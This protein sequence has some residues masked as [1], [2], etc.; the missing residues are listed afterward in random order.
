[1]RQTFCKGSCYAELLSPNCFLGEKLRLLHRSLT[2]LRRLFF[3]R[4]LATAETL[5]RPASYSIG[6]P[7]RL[8]RE[9]PFDSTMEAA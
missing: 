3:L 4:I 9:V 8:A 7:N 1:M 2:D 6:A 5:L